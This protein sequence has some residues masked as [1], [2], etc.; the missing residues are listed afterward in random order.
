MLT[1]GVFSHLYHRFNGL[2]I[3]AISKL[4]LC[5]LKVFEHI[6][7]VS[8]VLVQIVKEL[9]RKIVITV[10]LLLFLLFAFQT[11][12]LVFGSQFFILS[13]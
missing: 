1:H 4:L 11:K 13:Q 6:V 5:F 3:L 7:H 8:L 2:N 9:V 12:G 10:S